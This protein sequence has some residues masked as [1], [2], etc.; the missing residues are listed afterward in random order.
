MEARLC[1][2]GTPAGGLRGGSG[3]G[4][5][6]LDL[7]DVNGDRVADFA[8]AGRQGGA[9][10]V[11]IYS[12]WG[13][14]ADTSTG[15][16]PLVL[17]TIDDPL[18]ARSGP[19]DLALADLDGDGVSE[20]VVSAARGAAVAAWKFQVLGP[21]PVNALV[22]PSLLVGPT[23]L[24]GFRGANGLD[25]AS[26]DLDGDGRDELFVGQAG[27]GGPARAVRGFGLDAATGS[28]VQEQV[29]AAPPASTRGGGGLDAG[30]LTGDGVPDLVVASKS[31]GRVSMYDGS[32]GRWT[33][34]T[35]PLRARPG[36]ARVA[37]VSAE[38]ATGSVVVTAQVG[39]RGAAQAAIVP[40]ADGQA[41]TFLP[42][43][44]PGGGALVPL[45]A[46]YVYQRSTLQG[47]DSA[48]PRSPGPVTP[49][50][51]FASTSGLGLV[52]QGFGPDYL[53]S[54]ADT[55]VEPLSNAPGA[56]FTPL[57][58]RKGAAQGP[59]SAADGVNLIA[60]PEIAYTSPYRVDLSAA[61]A[62]FDAGL[63][64]RMVSAP[65]GDGWGPRR[66]PNEPPAVPKDASNDWLRQRVIAA[67]L[68]ALGV[69][70]QHH[71]DPT[72]LPPQG[73]TWNAT[74]TVAYQSRGVDCTN[75]TA[76]AYA[77]ALG[78]TINS[79]TPQQAAIRF[80]DPNGTV[81]PA[82]LADRVAIQ[83]IDRWTSYDDL[84]SQL[85]P[86]DILFINGDD[87]RPGVAT[88]AITWLGDYAVDANG[89]DRNLI[90]D[91]TGITPQHV[92]SN[93][94]VV[95]EG[96]QIRPFGAPGSANDWYYNHVGHVLRLIKADATAVAPI[97]G[98]ALPTVHADDDL[99]P[100]AADRSIDAL[101]VLRRRPDSA[102]LPSL[103]SLAMKPLDEREF[104]T[105]EQFAARYGADPADVA[106]VERWALGQGLRVESVDLATRT[107]RLV[108]KA[109]DME[110]AL[111]TRLYESGS[112]SDGPWVYKGEIGVPIALHGA[113]QG[114]FSVD[115]LPGGAGAPGGPSGLA[116]QAAPP[117]NPD[118]YTPP[119]LADRYK[120]PEA[121]G[122]GQTVGVIEVA[123]QIDAS[124]REDF[125]AY[126]DYL[127]LPTPEIVAVGQGRP[128]SDDEMY[129]DI[130]TLG[131]L[132]PGAKMV[133]YFSGGMG[134][135]DFFLTIQQ[136][137]H[138]PEH[139]IDVLSMSDSFPEPYLS[140]MFLDVASEA[141][142]EA[143]VMG[144]SAFVSAG[145]YGSSRDIPDGLA[146]VEFPSV[147]PWVTSVGGTRIARGADI[148]D[149]VVWD[150]YTIQ[151]GYLIGDK[152]STGG[153]VSRHFETPSYQRGVDRGR[154]PRSVDP[155]HRAGRGGPDVASVADPHTGILIRARGRFLYD[156]GTSA[157]APVWAGLAAR[158]NQLLGRNVGFYN[159]LLYGPLVGT[160]STH[161][162]T[163]GDNVSSHIDLEG[164][165]I[166]TYL[167]YEAHE[168]WDMTTGWGSPVGETLLG[169]LRRL[170]RRG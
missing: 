42:A 1:L 101:L 26:A 98:S 119:Q 125:R 74:T 137:I 90:I 32:L 145:D 132:V 6:A 79:D 106:A 130:E 155:G 148:D 61:P 37:I 123:G 146:H 22:S 77:D 17:A 63:W 49:T 168:G 95:P 40:Y 43:A 144:V 111:G 11:T 147:S 51:L 88:H 112:S 92:D 18:G 108:G 166:P 68:S 97:A 143:A 44:S 149:E 53:P 107:V 56:A 162:V 8:V 94:R 138:D 72:W 50:V 141:F 41:R 2:S 69:D 33:W 126:F 110:G 154:D 60:F 73:S 134:P 124:A 7:G 120:F 116:T 135:G 117:D 25:L 55:Y 64:D 14:Q 62:G 160:G 163:R 24:P 87:S 89:A 5:D 39:R 122:S 131:A 10:R 66:D 19:L 127:G 38:G 105:R 20:L 80:S 150:T 36:T 164:N 129:L 142:L 85:L 75:L 21:S 153:G 57:Q 99:K 109:S 139:R 3:P 13:Q 115:P 152:G 156:G 4:I 100:L 93:G 140:S 59:E 114:V 34:S 128:A 96:V 81:I 65:S 133:V 76:W 161:D 12:G 28:W 118:G 82:S 30:D 158:L 91:S 54:L 121:D 23:V 27:P 52:V 113:I 45:G 48:F 47:L 157:G 15:A 70:Y 67:Y 58:G 16:A 78:V 170:L 86:G 167:G 169:S 71:Y 159:P 102:G 136:A 103:E 165:Q 151:D 84:V 83:T 31:D 46:G 29:F 9:T 104:L 35:A